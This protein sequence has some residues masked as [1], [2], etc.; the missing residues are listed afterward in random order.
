MV[1]F[2][3]PAQNDAQ[4]GQSLGEGNIPDYNVVE[5][6]LEEEKRKSSRILTRFSFC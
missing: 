2:R 4:G 3:R 6:I 1:F 5:T